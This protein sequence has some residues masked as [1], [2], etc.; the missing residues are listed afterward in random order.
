MMQPVAGTS[1][2]TSTQYLVQATSRSSKPKSR[3]VTVTLG[4]SD[5]TRC[6]TSFSDIIELYKQNAKG[7]PA[8][9]PGG[10]RTILN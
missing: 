1:G 7:K 5:T 4:W 3:R 6:G 10:W 9:A 2:Q 8:C